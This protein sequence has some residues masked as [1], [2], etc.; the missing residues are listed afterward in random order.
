MNRKITK[1]AIR[2]DLAEVRS[3]IKRLQQEERWLSQMLGEGKPVPQRASDRSSVEARKRMVL[4]TL[5]SSQELTTKEVCEA[6][7][8]T[9]NTVLR[10][11]EQLEEEGAVRETTGQERFR[12]WIRTQVRIRPGQE[13]N[14]R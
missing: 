8:Y 2:H 14:G 13:T 3:E 11:L 9:P 5:N 12:R 6:A 1:A 7:G 4:A 10:Y